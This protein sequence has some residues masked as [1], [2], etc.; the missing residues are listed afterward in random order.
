MTRA[1][2]VRSFAWGLAVMLLLTHGT[3]AL[4]SDRFSNFESDAW[5]H[6]KYFDRELSF[7]PRGDEVLVR[8]QPG[9]AAAIEPVVRQRLGLQVLHPVQQYYHHAH[10]RLAPGADV[11]SVSRDLSTESGVISAFPVLVDRDGYTKY[12]VGHELTVR[13]RSGLDDVECRSLI[14]SMGSEVA[15]DHWTP[16]YYTITVPEKMTLF[17]AIRAYNKMDEVRY[18]EFSSVGYDDLLMVPNDTDYP[19]QQNLN[20][21]GQESSLCA[22]PPYADHDIRAEAAWDISTGSANVVVAVIDTGADL[23]HPDLAGNIL[24]RGTEDWDFADP[25]DSVPEDSNGHGTSCSGIVAAVTN[26]G[27][28]VAGI[29]HD[30]QVMPL[31]VDLGSGMNQNRADAINYA[32]GR[33]GDFDGLV[34][35]NS[36]RMSSGTYTA[37]YDA[38]QAA[39]AAG[40]VVVFASGN[41]GGTAVD[42]PSDSTHCIAVGATSPCDEQKTTSSCD[43]ESWWGSNAGPELDVCAPGV[44]IHTTSLGGGYTSTFNGTSSAT[45][46]VAAVAALILSV[47]PAL[48]PDE[49]QDLLEASAVDIESAG[50]DNETGWGRIDAEAA[51][52]LTS[53]GMGPGYC[54]DFDRPDSSTVAGWTEQSGNW[55]IN[56]NWLQS[57]GGANEYITYDGSDQVNGAVR[58]EGEYGSGASLRYVAVHARYGSGSGIY[59]KVQDNT[60]AGDFNQYYIYDGGGLAASGSGSFGTNPIIELEYVGTSVN[61]RVDTDQD[62]IWEYDFPAAV[63]TLG[64]GLCGV[65]SYGTV[66]FNDFCYGPASGLWTEGTLC[67]SFDMAD[68]TAVADWTEQAG[69]WSIAGDRLESQAAGSLQ[70]ITRDGSYQADGC[71]QG[72]AGYGSGAGLRYVGL[73]ARYE[74]SNSK[75]LVKLQ[76][77]NSTGYFDSYYVYDDNTIVSYQSSGLNFG[78][79]AM[80]ELEYTG[81]SVTFRVDTDLDGNWDHVYPATV[82][83][84]GYGLTGAGAYQQCTLDDWCFGPDG[85]SWGGDTTV[86]FDGVPSIYWENDGAQNLDGY[87]AG[88]HFGPTATILEAT[89][90]G[91][92]SAG[93]PY[94]SADAVLYAGGGTDIQVDLNPPTDHVGFWYAAGSDDLVLEAYNSAGA[95]LASSVGPVNVGS[96]DYLQVNSPGIDHVVIRGAAGYYVIDDFEWNAGTPTMGASFTCWPT[97]GTVPFSTTMSLQLDN[98]YAAQTRRLA[99]R[100]NVTLASGLY[101]PSWRAGFTNVAGGSNYATSWTTNI[102][103]LGS[104]IG[105]NTFNLVAEDVTPAPYNQPPFPPAGHADSESCVIVAN[106]P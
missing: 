22:C 11:F 99:G 36:W 79:S 30:C 78:T 95:M 82:A 21:T 52:L 73:V 57:P 44:L 42:V 4:A 97:S 77:N 20:N 74:S 105:S 27:Q 53:T 24:A 10:Y 102:P 66:F 28:G 106:S 81:T 98:L 5:Y 71:V 16:G 13:F 62:G 6:D 61:F 86:D 19:D 46:H 58:V 87:Y 33:V 47:N 49:V 15:Q 59:A 25:S 101:F 34:L 1:R 85:D 89:V 96:N 43:G 39:K 3:L 63:T 54:D 100:I 93:Y 76:D 35:S 12:V 23:D 9:A 26:N 18:A 67:E 40:C 103:A 32:A 51:L 84:T 55:Q 56:G 68:G 14:R 69:D 70:Y 60:S 48:T 45:P 75:I 64:S 37:V 94:H 8:F 7:T 104:V 92:N 2:Y 80:L 83:N 17:Q 90:H 31:R 38:I 91:Y 88:L 65:N 29:A 41:G 72:L 50:F